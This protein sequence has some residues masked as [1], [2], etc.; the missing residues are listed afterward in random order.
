[1]PIREYQAVDPHQGCATCRKPFE[2]LEQ[3]A[4]SAL[5]KCPDCGAPLRR[6]I[7]AAAVGAS[8]SSFDRRAQQ[9]GFHKLKRQGKGEYEKQY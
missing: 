3:V 2:R 9:S 5:A 4:G 7:S 6:L 8:Q 1:M